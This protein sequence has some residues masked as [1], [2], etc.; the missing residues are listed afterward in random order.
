M[1]V[2]L[3]AA[4]ILFVESL[5]EVAKSISEDLA[6]E[7]ENLNGKLPSLTTNMEGFTDF[8]TDF[9]DATVTYAE[10]SVIAGLSGTISN[11]IKFFTGDPISNLA[12]SVNEVYT[13]SQTLETNLNNANPV[14]GRVKDL[15][16]TYQTTLGEIE[17]LTGISCITRY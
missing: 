1:L 3:S 16:D 10:S 8:M 12:D 5:S 6:P 4:T 2:E 7:L 13:Q 14:L 17:S 15:L 9:A 11:I